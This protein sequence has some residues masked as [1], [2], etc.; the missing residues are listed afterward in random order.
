[1]ED[2]QH[3]LLDCRAL[4]PI[5]DRFLDFF[6]PA[7]LP[8]SDKDTHVQFI[9][10]H[11]DHVQ[12]FRCISAMLKRRERCLQL[13]QEGKLSD[14]MPAG[15]LPEDRNMRR[16]MAADAWLEEEEAGGQE[17]EADPHLIDIDVSSDWDEL[18]EV[19]DDV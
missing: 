18:V 15:Y 11:H 9:L 8:R 10:N 17:V 4:D 2:L 19:V 3:F 13:V 16:I 14:I 1:M 7:S 5:R 12:L 6:Q